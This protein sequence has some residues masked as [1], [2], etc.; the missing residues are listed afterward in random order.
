MY[1]PLRPATSQHLPLR[2][3]SY[4]VR[5][6]GQ[7]QPGSVPLV[8]LHGW[9]DVS[10]SWQF[11]VDA[12]SQAFAQGR[13]IIAPDWR[14][15]GLTTAPM[16]VDN[17]HLV[18]YLADLDALLHQ[19]VP[20][21]GPVDLVGHSMGGNVSMLYAGARPARIRRLVNLEG[22]GL[23]PTRPE[24]A[25]QR[26]GQWLDELQQCRDGALALK[27]YASVDEVAQRLRKT[28]PRLPQDK[29]L[30]LAGQWA[31][32]QADG[33][34]AI[35]GD[36]AHKVVNPHLFR[37]EETLA[38]YAAITAPLL[39][40]EAADDSLASWSKGEYT[41]A[42]YHQRLQSVARHRVARVDD[43]AH[44]LHHDQPAAVAQLIEDFCSAGD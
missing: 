29:A 9:M 16:A 36:A 34:W 44:M 5:S 30:W 18:D 37:L 3:L 42:Q 33:R 25:P 23:A 17:Y 35:L 7:A 11:V 28:N 2:T 22:F 4:H 40:V 38:H 26:I 24:Q 27:S 15:F 32:P 14:G 31:A 20:D 1:T 43:A 6:W 8:L 13:H 39:A 12:F 10:A 19:L 21:G 41:L